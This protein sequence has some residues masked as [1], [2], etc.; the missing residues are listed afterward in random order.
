MTSRA[1]VYKTNLEGAKKKKKKILAMRDT[2]CSI[3]DIPQSKNEVMPTLP[4]FLKPAL[5]SISEIV[6]ISTTA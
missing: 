2:F 1:V 5:T 4:H 6:Y 3:R